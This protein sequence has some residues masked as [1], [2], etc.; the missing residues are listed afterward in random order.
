MKTDQMTVCVVDGGMF[1]EFALRLAR[2]G[3]GRVLY[4]ADIRL[5]YPRVNEA[6]IGDGLPGIERVSDVWAAKNVDV[7]AFPD[8]SH[9]ELQRELRRQGYPVWGS[10]DGCLLEWNRVSFR[11]K[12]ARL[13]L[14]VRPYEVIRGLKALGEYLSDKTDQFIRISRFRGNGET[15]HWNDAQ[16]CSAH[17]DELAIEYGPLQNEIEFL[18]EEGYDAVE[19]GYD[20]YFCGGEFPSRAFHGLEAKDKGYLG[21]LVDYD[22]LPDSLRETNEK[23]AP[24]LASYGY[25]N[26]F[27]SEVRIAED[28]LPYLEDPTC[29]HASPAGE[30]LL[31]T[32]D[33]L[34]EVVRQGAEGALVEP[35]FNARFSAQALIE[36]NGDIQKWRLLEVPDSVR[37]WVKLYNVTKVG[38]QTYAFP[39][40]AHSFTAVGSVLGLGDTAEEAVEAL[41]RNADFVEG[42]PASVEVRSLADALADMAESEGEAVHLPTG[43]TTPTPSIVLSDV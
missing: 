28:G 6:V 12:I 21:V 30:P 8:C 39:P 23:I 24:L 37:R 11:K 42:Q 1:V 31:E 41:K 7:W 25:A 29:R 18:V 35:D 9:P 36:H 2:E 19:V 13:G 40:L 5:P 15:W 34:P 10:G 27:S 3:F 33:N 17:L 43:Q 4:C 20:G 16:T 38:E 22:E 14:P 26:F 32:I